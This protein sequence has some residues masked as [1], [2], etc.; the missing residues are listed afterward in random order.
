[1]K[2]KILCTS[3]IHGYLAPTNYVKPN[4]NMPFGLEKAATT[5]K[6]EQKDSDHTLILDDGDFLEGSPLAYYSAEVVKHPSAKPINAAYDTI[7]YDFGSL[8]NHEFNY[9][10]AYLKDTIQNTKR[11]FVCANILNKNGEP[12]FGKPY[13]IKD[14]GDLKVGVL[15][16]T[17]QAINQWENKANVKGLQFK[18]GLETAQKYVP[19][20]KKEADIIVVLYHGG[21]ERDK[22]G[23]LSEKF[24]GENESYQILEQVPGI[25]ALVTGHQHRKLANHLFGVP[26][27]QP[28]HRGNYVGKITLDIDDDKKVTDSDAKLISTAQNK[29]YQPTKNIVDPID[30]QVERWLSKPLS[31]ING[32]LRYKDPFKVRT[33]GSSF[34]NFIQRVQME[35]MGV[36]ISATA[37][38]TDE[39]HGFEN[40]ITMRNIITNYVYPN[41]L[42]VLNITGKDLKA[43]LEKTAEY[44]AL[45]DKQIIVNPAYSYPKHRDYNYDMYA[46]IDYTIDVSKPVGS[47]I[48]NLTY[49]GRPVKDQQPLKIVLNAYRAVGGGH[50]SMYDESKIVSYNTIT[51]SNLIAKYLQSHPI[52]DA[53]NRQNFKVIS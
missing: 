27:V 4:E 43:A 38:F 48:T 52:I 25:D 45:K 26:Y 31:K 20:M 11:Q 49:H 28:G 23:K 34:I 50:Y 10:Q 18:S 5:I 29:P 44:F 15:G 19:I 51:M 46:G 36:D 13:A 3:D 21:F 8:G 35:T 14:F 7:N 32:S 24:T 33:Q 47:R 53:N 16:L 40:P 41:T 37:L 12:A 39:A 30:Q 1:M 9:G 2:L 42:A 17:T 6:Q 22:A